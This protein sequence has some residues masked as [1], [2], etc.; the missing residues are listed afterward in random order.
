MQKKKTVAPKSH[1][2][3]LGHATGN[4]M[5]DDIYS[6]IPE[7]CRMQTLHRP[8]LQENTEQ[9]MSRADEEWRLQYNKAGL[10]ESTNNPRCTWWSVQSC[11]CALGVPREDGRD[12]ACES[13]V[14]SMPR[15]ERSTGSRF[16]PWRLA[17]KHLLC[18]HL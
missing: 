12:E 2:H 16:A 4:N 13:E 1:Q 10:K 17:G 14:L 9:Q 6:K 15:Q 11:S 5:L 18:S 8:S 3:V 7:S